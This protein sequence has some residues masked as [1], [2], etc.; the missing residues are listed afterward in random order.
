VYPE[1]TEKKSLWSF[2]AKVA[3]RA[4]IV[5]WEKPFNN[6]RS[7][8]ATEL[9]EIF[10]SHIVNE[11]MGHT[12]A[13]AMAHYRQATGKAADKFFEQAAKGLP[14]KKIGAKMGVEHAGKGCSGVAGK[15]PALLQVPVFQPFATMVQG[16]QW[17]DFAPSDPGG[18]R[19]PNPR[20]RSHE[21]T[22]LSIAVIVKQNKGKPATMPVFQHVTTS[23]ILTI[24]CHLSIG[25]PPFWENNPHKFL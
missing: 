2:I 11:W 3:T 22:I 7:T 13:V 17:G 5:L 20:F 19:T 16:V 9:V 10:P 15:K 21:G 1:I 8:R 6:M 4:G 25:K 24:L 23:P 12:E 18:I 14:V